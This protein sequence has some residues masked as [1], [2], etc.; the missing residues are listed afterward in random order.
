MSKISRS[1]R[2]AKEEGL[3]D[4]H[5]IVAIDGIRLEN[6]AQY[7]IAMALSAQK[8]ETTIISWD[9]MNYKENIVEQSSTLCLGAI[10]A[11]YPAAPPA[12]TAGRNILQQKQ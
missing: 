6:A 9:G 11:N 5:I 12:A 4:R 3:R 8:P 1:A 2:A 10:M 7:K